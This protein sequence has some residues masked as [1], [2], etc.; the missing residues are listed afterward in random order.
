MYLEWRARKE[1]FG[2]LLTREVWI[3]GQ[4]GTTVSWQLNLWDDFYESVSC[5]SDHLPDL[6]N[7]H[8]SPDHSYNAIHLLF[9]SLLLSLLLS[10]CEANWLLSHEQ[11]R[12]DAKGP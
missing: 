5:I 11:E 9:S 8:Q 4:S 1:G 12:A 10:N 6:Q 3:A 2:F 7:R